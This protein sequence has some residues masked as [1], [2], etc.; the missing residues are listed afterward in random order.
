M[1]YNAKH[2]THTFRL[3]FAPWSVFSSQKQPDAA[4]SPESGGA[5][6][7]PADQPA[8]SGGSGAAAKP[9]APDAPK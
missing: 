6:K 3:I 5:V 7:V 8:A 1:G 9:A 4:K 2:I